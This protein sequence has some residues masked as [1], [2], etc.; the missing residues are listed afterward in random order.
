L[1]DLLELTLTAAAAVGGVGV[2]VLILGLDQGQEDLCRLP[3]EVT[4]SDATP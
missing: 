3:A 1:L 4:P 2:E